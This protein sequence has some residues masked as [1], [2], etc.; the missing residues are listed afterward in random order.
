MAPTTR[1][2]TTAEASRRLGLSVRSIHRR[3]AAG[4]LTGEKIGEGRNS[5]YLIPAAQVEA[6]E[7]RVAR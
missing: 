4:V 1:P 7:Q 6:L 2:V 3:I 5:A